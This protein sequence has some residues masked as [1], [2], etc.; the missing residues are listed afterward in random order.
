MASPAFVVHACA[1]PAAV[2]CSRSQQRRQHQRSIRRYAGPACSC[3]PL[4]ASGGLLLLRQLHIV[5]TPCGCHCGAAYL[6]RR[7]SAGVPLRPHLCVLANPVATQVQ[8]RVLLPAAAMLEAARAAAQQLV[9]GSKAAAGADTAA[10]AAASIPAPLILPAGSDSSGGS[11]ALP[12]A[13]CTVGFSGAANPAV[14]LESRSRAAAA[15]VTNLAAQL[16]SHARFTAAAGQPAHAGQALCQLLV[17]PVPSSAP[18][19]A[20]CGSIQPQPEHAAP[21][22]HCHPAPLDATLHLGMFA[23]P[24]ASSSA[25]PRVPVGA[26]VF[27][28]ASSGDSSSSGSSMWPVMQADSASAL[29]TVASYTLL[30]SSCAA[31]FSL[32]QLESKA[33]GSSRQRQPAAVSAGP[34][35]TSYSIRVAAHTP[36]VAVSTAGGSTAALSLSDSTGRLALVPRGSAAAEDVAVFGATQKALALLCSGGSAGSLH[37]Q[38]VT[39]LDQPATTA[40]AP[41]GQSATCLAAVAVQGLL[42]AA[43]AEAPAAAALPSFVSRSYLQPAG[44]TAEEPAAADVFAAPQ[45]DHGTWL[46]SQL[47]PEQHQLGTAPAGT[48]AQQPSGST[49]I[50]GGLGSL[51][52]STASWLAAAQQSSTIRLLGRSAS[53]SLPQVLTASSC[54]V[55]ARQCDT[56]AAADVA[57]AMCAK[58]DTTAYIHAG[59]LLFFSRTLLGCVSRLSCYAVWPS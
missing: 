10:L 38:A 50:S 1:T 43:S 15:A 28:A 32:Q 51:G 44:T 56:A 8:G 11:A 22:W 48:A 37:L 52:L 7:C 24:H 59:G 26:T 27:A 46:L 17:S 36:A 58:R 53:S 16:C 40:S 31:A 20:A 18:A 2:Q 12:L 4:G 9:D 35:L 23:A 45:L 30:S 34:Q 19:A 41:A 25:A 47:L 13:R 57:A 3:V 6:Q 55:T 39:A 49:T 21:G 29:T 5:R 33:V 54:L 14:R 42:K